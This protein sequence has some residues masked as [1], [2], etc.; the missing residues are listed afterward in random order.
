[1]SEEPISL[2]DARKRK[3]RSRGPGGSG[4]GPSTDSDIDKAIDRINSGH[5]LVLIGDKALVLRETISRDGKPEVGFLT[6]TA[7]RLWFA[8]EVF[9]WTNGVMSIGDIWLS[10]QRRRQYRSIEFA[11]DG[12]DP[13]VYNLWHG[14]AV[15]PANPLKDPEEHRIHFE[16]F[17]GHLLD[18]VCGG[19][20]EVYRWV[21][22]WFA[23]MIQRPTERLGTALVLRGRQGT[24]KTTVGEVFGRLVGPHY[25]LVD[26]PRYLVGQFNAHMSSCLLLQADEGFW[27]GDKEAEG[28]L[29][30]LITSGTHFIERKGVDPVPVRNLVRLMVTSNNDWVVPAGMEERRFAVLDVGDAVMQNAG[31]FREMWSELENG[32]LSHLLTYCQKFDLASVDLRKI[33]A[34]SALFEQKVSSLDPIPSWWYERL[35]AGSPTAHLSNWPGSMPTTHLY[36]SYVN[37]AER[38]GVRRKA[39]PTQFG[40]ALRRLIPSV[41]EFKRVRLSVQQY[42][43]NGEELCD[44]NGNPIMKRDWGY[45]LP[46]L[47]VCRLYFGE[48]LHHAIDWGEPLDGV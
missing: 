43:P 8:N 1:M 17:D 4:A 14:F 41:P 12:T 10:H 45:T 40:I 19:S 31:Y 5:A 6:P 22:G 34:T 38:L 15:K 27:A 36:S 29:K 32:G 47:G 46:D 35:Q 20:Y 9:L 33:P 13:D 23:H 26:D 42:G 48:I 44:A 37:Y 7:F 2:A 11:P 25:A 21:F 28:K 18:N 16:K 24:G 30:G 3:G 39:T